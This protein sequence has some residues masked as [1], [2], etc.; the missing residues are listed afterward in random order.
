MN[1]LLVG[2]G[3]PFQFLAQRFVASGHHVTMINRD[4]AECKRLARLVQGTVVQ[5][6]GSDERI[7]EEA[8]ARTAGIVLAATEADADNLLICQTARTRFGVPR[9][10]ALVNDP[11]NQEI[12]QAL[13]I[14][15]ISTALTIASLIE[16]RAELDQVTELIPAAQGKATLSEIVLT[17]DCSAI[18]KRLA[19]LAVPRDAL[20]AVLLR[21]GDAVIPRG[22]TVLGAGDR[23][24]VVAL[25]KARDTAL[26]FFAGKGA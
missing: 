5:G 12:F 6:D 17:S 21:N 24:L 19:D 2:G 11:D 10:V 20:V 18:G 7:L 25:A 13:G 9:A 23:V 8:G 4:A 26:A 15:A 3:R 14:D 16:Q 22:D 1:V